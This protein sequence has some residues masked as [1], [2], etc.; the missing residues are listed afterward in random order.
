MATTIRKTRISDGVGDKTIW[1][2]M[3]YPIKIKRVYKTVEIENLDKAHKKRESPDEAGNDSHSHS[4]GDQ[5]E[6]ASHG[7]FSI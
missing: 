1:Q 5:K 4:S 3:T 7:S 2:Y 6:I